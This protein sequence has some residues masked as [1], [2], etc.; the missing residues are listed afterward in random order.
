MHRMHRFTRAVV[1]EVLSSPSDNLAVNHLSCSRTAVFRAIDDPVNFA[2]AV[3]PPS[4][5]GPA[6]RLRRGRCAAA[7]RL[8]E[9]GL[10]A[11]LA[12]EVLRGCPP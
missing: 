1:R 7:L 9:V 11:V 3:R 8:F 5:R 12:R 6:H 4:R 10:E 2:V